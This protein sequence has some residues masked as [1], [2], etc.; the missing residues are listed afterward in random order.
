M[1]LRKRARPERLTVL[2]LK[3]SQDGDDFPAPGHVHFWGLGPLSEA[4]RCC[5]LRGER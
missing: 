3:P 5:F 4:E 2:F 1:A